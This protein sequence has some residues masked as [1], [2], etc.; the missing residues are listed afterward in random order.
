MKRKKSYDQT[1]QD[2]ESGLATLGDVS[3]KKT[4][5]PSFNSQPNLEE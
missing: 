3:F 5:S 4:S 1:D 2:R